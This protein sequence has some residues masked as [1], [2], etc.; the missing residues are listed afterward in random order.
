MSSTAGAFIL[1]AGALATPAS[2][3]ATGPGGPVNSHVRSFNFVHD[4]SYVLDMRN[5]G[6]EENTN[7]P[8]ATYQD[9]GFS[10]IQLTHDIGQP[11]GKCDA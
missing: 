2:A 7:I 3:A 1:L 9:I 11:Q 5:A 10:A 6:V 8:S 4:A